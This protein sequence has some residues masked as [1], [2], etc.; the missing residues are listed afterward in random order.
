MACEQLPCIH[1]P[2]ETRIRRSIWKIPSGC[3]VVSIQ[4]LLVGRCAL[5]CDP[6]MSARN[7]MEQSVMADHIHVGEVAL[8]YA[9][10]IEC[11]RNQTLLNLFTQA[12]GLT[13]EGCKLIKVSSVFPGNDCVNDCLDVMG[14]TEKLMR[15][16]MKSDDGS[17]CVFI[18]VAETDDDLI[19]LACSELENMG[20]ETILQR[21]LVRLPDP[22]AEHW[23]FRVS[24]KGIIADRCQQILF[25]V[26]TPGQVLDLLTYD[27]GAGSV[28][29]NISLADPIPDIIAAIRAALDSESPTP[30][31]YANVSLSVISDVGVDNYTLIFKNASVDFSVL[32]VQGVSVFPFT[33]TDCN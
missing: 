19:P 24:T 11:D 3:L 17:N 2:L 30:I 12:F 21:L 27:G 23:A 10:T 18:L 6:A 1:E 26:N 4:Q 7:L 5:E 15:T 33:I 14:I 29:L 9:E 25:S 8:P 31:T 20:N 28:N 32:V 22:Y 16:F 13:D